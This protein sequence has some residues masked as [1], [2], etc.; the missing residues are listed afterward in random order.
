M[1]LHDEAMPDTGK[2]IEALIIALLSPPDEFRDRASESISG[3]YCV[4]LGSI[5]QNPQFK[6]DF[7]PHG[8]FS[9]CV[10]RF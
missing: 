4:A 5:F 7:T 6:W 3:F 2:G 9:I 8:R 10:G 1:A